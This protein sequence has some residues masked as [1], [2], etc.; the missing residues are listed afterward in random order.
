MCITMKLRVKFYDITFEKSEFKI[1]GEVIW[2]GFHDVRTI[3]SWIFHQNNS[4]HEN[5]TIISRNHISKT[6]WITCS[7]SKSS[8][9]KLIRL[10]IGVTADDRRL[11]PI[12]S[13]DMR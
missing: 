2:F 5:L 6:V 12:R 3:T 9:S 4:R 13:N 8:G 11:V 10:S 1:P 7:W